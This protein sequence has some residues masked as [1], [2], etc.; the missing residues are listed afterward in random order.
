MLDRVLDGIAAKR[1]KRSRYLCITNIPSRCE[2][3]EVPRG[4]MSFG[5][6]HVFCSKA[7]LT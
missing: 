2:S 3:A 5:P 1:E 6:N 4:I 7:Q